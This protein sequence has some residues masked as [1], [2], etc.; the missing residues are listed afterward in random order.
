MFRLPSPRL[1]KKRTQQVGRHKGGREL[2]AAVGFCDELR[3]EAG[4]RDGNVGKAAQKSEPTSKKTV[5]AAAEASGGQVGCHRGRGAS[6]A[7]FVLGHRTIS[8]SALIQDTSNN[9]ILFSRPRQEQ[10][11]AVR[12][13]PVSALQRPASS[14]VEE[15]SG[16]GIPHKR[17]FISTLLDWRQARTVHISSIS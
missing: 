7:L 9:L 16:A 5:A 6:L 4:Q 17:A 12:A 13:V 3:A 8:E 2:L 10:M 15:E 1:K 14:V 11:V